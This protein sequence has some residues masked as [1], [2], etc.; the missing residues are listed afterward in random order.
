MPDRYDDRDQDDAPLAFDR[1]SARGRN[2][3]P[4]AL[5]VSL[6]VL[7]AAG[8]GV[9]MLYRGGARTTDGPPQP[10]GAPLRDVKTA[11]PPQA[12]VADPAAGLTIYRDNPNATP[13]AP[14]FAPAPEEPQKPAPPQAAI[15]PAQSKVPRPLYLGPSRLRRQPVPS[16]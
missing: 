6:L 3:A 11:A 1:R 8:G 4:V 9:F 15:E 13:S 2:P 12:Q 16:R 7:L 5:I 10:V 14:A